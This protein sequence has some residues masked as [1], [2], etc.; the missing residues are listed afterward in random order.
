MSEPLARL[1]SCLDTQDETSLAG[2]A[3]TGKTWHIRHILDRPGIVLCAPTARAMLRLTEVTKTTAC[4]VHGLIYGAPVSES[5]VRPDGEVCTSELAPG[6][7]GCACRPQVVFALGDSAEL[8]EGVRLIVVDEASMINEQVATDIRAVAAKLGAKLLFVGD[9]GQ[10]RPVDGKPGVALDRAD[11]TLT[12]VW[13]NAGGILDFVSAVRAAQTFEDLRK[14]IW[15]RTYQ[16]VEVL[17]T[18]LD[19]LAAWRSARSQRMAIVHSNKQRVATNLAV[20][21]TLGFPSRLRVGDRLLI[22][23]NARSVPCYNGEVYVAKSTVDHDPFTL[24]RVGLDGVANPV[25]RTIVV[26]QTHLADADANEFARSF[27]SLGV[28]FRRLSGVRHADECSFHEPYSEDHR[29]A[30]DCRPGPLHGLCLVNAQFGFAITCHAAQGSEADE[31]GVLWTPRTHRDD[32]ESA[33]SWLYTAASR[34]KKQ[35]TIYVG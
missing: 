10:L 13:R 4:T 3:G 31:V 12:H 29:C 28:S 30:P 5:W 1:V 6:C 34:A 17:G 33:R 21:E 23:R 20:R 9:P 14:C 35:L 11:V 25:V 27:R 18:G 15:E 7:P 24:V 26:C 16:D 32:L 2:Y 19:G 8:L 22:R